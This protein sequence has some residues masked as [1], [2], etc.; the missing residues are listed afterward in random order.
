MM[1]PENRGAPTE[2]AL[3]PLA[4]AVPLVGGRRDVRAIADALSIAHPLA[5]SLAET[6]T[7]EDHA[8]TAHRAGPAAQSPALTAGRARLDWKPT[9]KVLRRMLGYFTLGGALIGLIGFAA[10]FASVS[11]AAYPYLGRGAFTLPLLVDLGIFT[12]SGLGIVLELH[13]ISSRWI[14]LI[15][16]G[17]AGFTIYLNTATQPTW[18]GKAV[19]AAGP[20]L[21]VIVVEIATFTVRRMVALSSENAMGKVRGARWLLAPISTFRLWRRMRLWEITSYHT[22]I[23]S[24]FERAASAALLRQW[25]GPAWRARAPRAERLAVR[26]L[27]ITDEPVAALLTRASTGITAAALAA[28]KPAR[29]G[30]AMPAGSAAALA[31]GA[32]VDTGLNVDKGV[33]S[34]GA[35]LLGA[36]VASGV[37]TGLAVDTALDATRTA[38]TAALAVPSAFG[39]GAPVPARPAVDSA[40]ELIRKGWENGWSVRETARH[41]GRDKAQVSRKFAEFD[42]ARGP[43]ASVNGSH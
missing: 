15:P 34:L 21:W 2:S 43:I 30:A 3:L 14:R 39:R 38:A 27:G 23:A 5:V 16:L 35:P 32:G 28:A 33:A 7:A 24:E 12:L 10:S 17:L 6:L 42:R 19:H 20:V 25:Y 18:F 41:A 29:H 22:A 8:T 26:L 1:T 9:A 4:R 37:D 31:A 13:E 11:Q 36:G 40:A